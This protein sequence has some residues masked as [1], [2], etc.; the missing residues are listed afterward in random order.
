MNLKK[1]NLLFIAL[2]LIIANFES[3]IALAQIKPADI[4]GQRNS[5]VRDRGNKI[6]EITG[7]T[8]RGNNLFHSFSEFSIP[9]GKE[10]RFIPADKI[11]NIFT[12]V[13]GKES[14]I[15]GT[16]KVEGQANLFLLNPKGISFGK[17][18][19]LDLKGSFMATTGDS[20]MF[21]DGS[22][23]SATNPEAPPLLK[24]ES[25]QPIGIR[26]EGSNSGE[27]KTNGSEFKMGDRQTLGLIGGKIEI[28]SS[29][30]KAP[31]G[32]IEL[33]SVAGNNTVGLKL[34][35]F[36]YQVDYNYKEVRVNKF[37]DINIS[38]DKD[39]PK[40]KIVQTINTDGERGGKISIYGNKINFD[41]VEIH[42][43]TSGNKDGGQL[44]ISAS[45]SITMN[46]GTQIST[47]ITQKGAGKAG[48]ITLN[49]GDAIKIDNAA[50]V[51]SR[52]NSEVS[53]K[54]G[55][56]T[57]DA[58][59]LVINNGGQIRND[60][61][62]AS[63]Q[64]EVGLKIIASDSITLSDANSTIANSVQPDVNG[65]GSLTVI[66]TKTLSVA[67][68]A[69]IYTYS[70]GN[71]NSGDLSIKATDSVTVTGVT[72]EPDGVTKK[73]NPSLITTGSQS[74]PNN[75]GNGGKLTI[76][77]NLLHVADGGQ[78]S[79]STSNQ[80]KAGTIK[81]TAE[82]TEIGLG[83]AK[84]YT[85]SG[86]FANVNQGATGNGGNITLKT[87]ELT[88]TNSGLIS[89]DAQGQG[90]AG[91]INI[92]A[93]TASLYRKSKITAAITSAN[94][95]TGG[96]INLHLGNQLLLRDGSEITTSAGDR[97]QGGQGGNIHIQTDFIVAFPQ[98][99][100][101]II[102][103]AF[104]GS[105]GEVTIEARN[106]FGIQPRTDFYNSYLSEI[107]SSNRVVINNLEVNPNISPVSTI[108]PINQ[109]SFGRLCDNKNE[110]ENFRFYF[111]G[112]GG[113]LPGI[114]MDVTVYIPDKS[115]IDLVHEKPSVSQNEVRFSDKSVAL[116][117][118]CE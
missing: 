27:I 54:S 16:L 96:N 28:L 87:R 56:I 76:T 38:K 82:N 59:K 18:A 14:K 41:S 58:K 1:T 70:L 106:L 3:Q 19:K 12:R 100:S 72:A 68:G 34:T 22:E 49:A 102:G 118:P 65:N 24:V 98:E 111:L 51:F 40:D 114:E 78:I 60:T 117:L 48:D 97:N 30:L 105:G 35:N 26:F 81:I 45:D 75:T 37:G 110:N 112:R 13:T 95:K 84:Q 67:K 23:F 33:G 89:V 53:G 25:P 21:S 115:W 43:N 109:F 64:Q 108:P 11:T 46:N 62:A 17:K 9:K 63:G 8:R 101:N 4:K 83:A 79:S 93:D 116:F 2:T 20:L 32:N 90:K 99:N 103:N 85:P 69:N 94:G 66:K 104:K 92:N 88:L 7:G 47:Q 55:T 36:G 77:T 52:T 6:Q 86:L 42:S 113:S 80:G 29:N 50:Q 39:A 10:A 5:L 74:N 44:K 107:L 61:Y 91:T 71:G 73:K 57:V 31:S 15:N